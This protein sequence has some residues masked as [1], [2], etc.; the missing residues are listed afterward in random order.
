MSAIRKRRIFLNT[1]GVQK[2][3]LRNSVR[4]GTRTASS[5]I[6]SRT[7]SMNDHAEP[8]GLIASLTGVSSATW[9]RRIFMRA[10]RHFAEGTRK[11]GLLMV[12]PAVE[13]IDLFKG[14]C[15]KK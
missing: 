8:G 10:R 12:A 7:C 11:A 5:T 4:G 15:C 1:A 13:G 6:R 3:I 14:L 2:N 9:N